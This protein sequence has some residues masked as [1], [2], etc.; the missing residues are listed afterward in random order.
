MIPRGQRWFRRARHISAA[1]ALTLAE[2]QL[3][4][5]ACQA[6]KWRR[7]IGSLVGNACTASEEPGPDL[8]E[9]IRVGWAVSRAARYG[10]FRPRCLVQA[11]AIQRML[12]RRGLNPGEL[13]I[14]VR[15]AD[16]RMVAHAWVELGEEI[17]GDVPQH[18]R[19]FTPAPDLRLVEL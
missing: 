6:A 3:T 9:A 15:L 16:G 14:G 13:R 17:I 1:E 19:S 10:F 5:L 2:A 12:R 7:P 4:L 18:V 11:L 8:A